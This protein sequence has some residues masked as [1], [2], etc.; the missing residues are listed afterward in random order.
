MVILLLICIIHF[1]PSSVP[2][3]MSGALWLRSLD[4]GT[5]S[6]SFCGSGSGYSSTIWFFDS[7]AI[8]GAIFLVKRQVTKIRTT[9]IPTKMS[10]IME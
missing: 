2:I 4:G 9:I 8:I 7:L 5:S 3:C 6:I 1:I 10:M